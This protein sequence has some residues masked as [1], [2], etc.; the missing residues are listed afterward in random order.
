MDAWT[1]NWRKATEA[2]S[3]SSRAKPDRRLGRRPS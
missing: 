1:E 3:R 2:F